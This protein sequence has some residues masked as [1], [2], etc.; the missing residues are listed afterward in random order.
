MASDSNFEGLWKA[1]LIYAPELPLPLAQKF[2]NKAYSRV[3]NWAILPNIFKETAIAIPTPVTAGTVSVT[4]GS[5]TVTGV[6]TAW[7]SDMANRQ[8]LFESRAPVYDIASVESTTSLTLTTPFIGVSNLSGVTYT[9][10]L[11]YLNMP[12]DF[13]SFRTITDPI[14]NWRLWTNFTQEQIDLLDSQ[15]RTSGTPWILAICKPLNAGTSTEVVRYEL[16]PRNTGG[17]TYPIK[18]IPKPALLSAPADRPAFPVRADIL[19]EG[20][21]AEVALWPGTSDAP[22]PYHDIALHREHEKRFWKGVFDLERELQ[23]QAQTWVAYNDETIPYAPIDA[24]YLQA[25]GIQ[26]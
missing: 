25:H 19:I 5:T 17:Q 6:G 22:N 10:N 11:I 3:L 14:N 4:V 7:T 12:S 16:W 23:M 9:I 2:I 13:M 1:L 21:L 26:F 20:A 24:A 8:L 15:R 18:Y